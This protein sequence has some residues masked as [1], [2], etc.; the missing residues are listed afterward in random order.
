MGYKEKWSNHESK[1][2]ADDK[3]CQEGKLARRL[4]ITGTARAQSSRPRLTRASF[5]CTCS[6][7]PQL[8][9][10]DFGARPQGL[11]GVIAKIA[12]IRSPFWARIG[13]YFPKLYK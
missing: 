13:N 7:A 5:W 8:A 10:R 4:S 6:A 12:L 1:G 2:I 3:E 11:T 9:M